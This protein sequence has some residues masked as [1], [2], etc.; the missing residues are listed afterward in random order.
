LVPN[1]LIASW[2][3]IGPSAIVWVPPSTVVAAS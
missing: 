1:I 3:A 2:L